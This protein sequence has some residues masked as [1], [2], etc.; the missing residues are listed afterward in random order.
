MNL[1]LL[2]LADLHLGANCAFLGEKAGERKKDF[3][4]AFERAMD[5]ARDAANGI[6]LVVIAGDLFDSHRPEPRLVELVRR[7]FAAVREAGVSIVLAPGTHDTSSYRDCVYR[8]EN[9]GDILLLSDDSD[10]PVSFEVGDKTVHIYGAVR[11]IHCRDV[12]LDKMSRISADGVHIGVMHAAVQPTSGVDFSGGELGVTLP[13][14]AK[15]RLDYIALGHYHNFKQYP[16]DGVT[17][18]YPGTLEGR[19]FRETGDRYLVTVTFTPGGPAVEKTRFNARTIR[20]E[21]IDLDRTPCCDQS[22]LCNRVES[23]ADKDAIVEFIVRGDAEF[24]FSTAAI[25]EMFADKFFYLRIVD[26][27]RVYC[28]RWVKQFRDERTVRGIFVRILIE[29]IDNASTDE[30]KRLLDMALRLGLTELAG[31]DAD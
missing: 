15:T 6:D 3:E 28:A 24:S 26:E 23:V 14:L 7:K 12:P 2:H 9:L 21:T 16:A 17:A 4:R 29:R 22:E 11:G 30:E 18:V 8:E 27:T 13:D 10:C 19:S 5:F 25:E 1:R 31:D 20:Q